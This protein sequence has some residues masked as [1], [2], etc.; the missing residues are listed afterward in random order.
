MASQNLNRYP[1]MASVHS[2]GSLAYVPHSRAYLPLKTSPGKP[3]GPN[4]VTVMNRMWRGS[5]KKYIIYAIIS[6][7]VALLFFAGGALYFG[8]R[9]VARMIVLNT[10][11]LGALMIAAGILFTGAFFHFMYK[12]N[13]ASD[14]WRSNVRFRAEGLCS[15]AAYNKTYS[16][17]DEDKLA[18][19]TYGP[20]A[21][22]ELTRGRTNRSRGRQ[23]L[24]SGAITPR[25]PLIYAEQD[26]SQTFFADQLRG[27]DSKRSSIQWPSKHPV[28][29]RDEKHLHSVQTSEF[30]GTKGSEFVADTVDGRDGLNIP[31]PP[32]PPSA[33]LPPVSRQPVSTA[34]KGNA[35]APSSQPHQQQ[36]QRAPQRAGPKTGPSAV[37][38]LSYTGSES[39]L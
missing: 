34:K 18:T 29:Q 25:T 23:G 1:S 5:G 4:F 6:L 39:E 19:G 24:R 11:V 31:Y 20:M 8:H 37:V 12:A 32:P 22:K 33:F 17:D 15:V 27:D 28:A 2:A 16:P 9:N 7:C 36:Q 13:V 10:E 30:R 14:R 35:G 38:R 26:M 3:Y 21:I